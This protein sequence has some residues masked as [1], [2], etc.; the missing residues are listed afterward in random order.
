M[1]LINTRHRF[2][3]ALAPTASLLLGES[4]PDLM[5]D[6]VLPDIFRA[7]LEK[8]PDR[9]VF[10]TPGKRYSYREVDEAANALA[11]GLVQRGIG[12]RDVVGLW[13]PRGVPVLVAQLAISRTG[14]AW[15]P[16][17]ADTPVERIRACLEDASAKA[18]LTDGERGTLL[19]GSGLPVLVDRTVALRGAVPPDPR[20][21]GLLPDHP[22][23][24]IY[25]SGSTGVPKGI[26]IT[27]RNI[28]HF[29]LAAR[30]TYGIA[31]SDVMF[32]GASVAFDLSM[33]E[34]WLPYAVGASL[35]VADPALMADLSALP[36]VLSRHGVTV[37]DTVPTLLSLLPEDVPSLRIIILG[38]EACPP[39]IASRWCRPGRRIFNSYGPTEATVVATAAEIR[40]GEAITIGKPIP[41]YSCYVVDE[42]L[43]LVAEGEEGELLIGGPGVARGYLNRPEL[44]LQKFVPNPFPLSSMDPVLYRTG[45]AVSVDAQGNL[46]FHGRLDDQVKIRG[47]RVELG[48][49]EARLS[50]FPGIRQA[51]VVLRK[52]DGIER[53]VGFLVCDPPHRAD[54]DALRADLARTLPGYMVPARLV[55]LERLPVLIS[56]KADRKALAAQPL[57]ETAAPHAAAHPPQTPTEE[58][59]HAAACALFPG[60]TL[61]MEAD[62][63]TDFGG[64][65]LLAARFLSLVRQ[66]PAHAGLG[67]QDVYRDRT[68]RAM[69]ARLDADAAG[70]AGAADLSFEPPPLLRRF[71]CGLA[72]AAA[73]PLVLGLMSAQFLG[74]FLAY[75]FMASGEMGVL[76]EMAALSAI[77][78]GINLLTAAI[79]IGLKWLVLGRTRPGRYP[80]WGVYYYRWWLAQRLI[81]LIHMKWVQ[82][83]PLMSG[84]LRLLGAR[85]GRD[86]LLYEIEAGAIDLLDIG[87]GVSVGGHC[88]FAN[89]QV[90]GNELVIGTIEIG[91]DAYIGSSCVIGG[92]SRIGRGAELGDLTA[93]GAGSVIGAGE[94]WDGSP[95][96][97]IGTV[98]DASLPAPATAG[99]LRRAANLAVYLIAILSIPAIGLIPLVP[100]FFLINRADA[101]LSGVTAL[102]HHWF[103]PLMALPAALGL[104]AAT[105][106]LIVAIRWLVLPRLQEG[107]Y[108]VHGGTY[109]R[110]WIVSLC[111]EV[112]LETLSSLYATVYM[113]GWYRLMGARI[114]K[115]SEISTSLSGRY[116]L[117][118]IGA[119]CF[120]AD[121]VLLGEED[122][123]RGWMTLKRVR[124]GDQVFVG[125]SAVVPVGT[126]IPDRCL[127][128]IKSKPPAAGAMAAGETWF[129][130][131]AIRLPVRQQ[132]DGGAA[133]TF[134]PSLLRQVG[135]GLFEAL[136][137]LSVPTVS[138]IYFGTLA[139][140]ALGAPLERGA[141]GTALL[142]LPV[143]G[144]AM[145]AAMTLIVVIL[146][147][148]MMG[149][150]R[151]QSNPMWSWFS[152]RTEAIAVMYSGMA[153]RMLLDFL[154]G[155][156]FLPWVLR[157]FGAR[158]GKGVYLD[159]TDITEFD[160]ICVGNFVAVNGFAALQTHL[161]EDR[162]MKIGRVRVEDGV[163]VEAGSTVLY[164]SEVG[165]FARL[166]P[167]TIVM[168][169][170]RI[171]PHTEWHGAP[172]TR[173]PRL[174]GLAL[175]IVTPGRC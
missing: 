137:N 117:V 12:P 66:N 175:Q 16:F 118:E 126:D 92:N 140:E 65:S 21:L 51:A 154:R 149:T 164:D 35:F 125:N 17:D 110:K 144:M 169:G 14:A 18:L 2:A 34:I 77:Y 119:K 60:A 63:F 50:A 101:W 46:R 159:M 44:T 129:G 103:L 133:R 78:L 71:L 36:G 19:A 84:L 40:P 114:G 102:D 68:L 9:T 75:W 64:H 150:Y 121:E 91:D 83:T 143:L 57:P 22:A 113:R 123:R 160:C 104:V 33:E 94:R 70:S 152:L 112:A 47:F 25:T 173:R 55:E 86:T 88:G 24:Y 8:G 52:D 151:P 67:L 73:M 138:M 155:T 38:G 99:R 80:L 15:L 107:V 93:I 62:F 163:T 135:R 141:Y 41:N 139:I 69:A 147:W 96:R 170:E 13:F 43:E 162:V 42:A 145:A 48:E 132:F 3:T 4:R 134:E 157:L 5:A 130:S 54:P 53:L 31:A 59:L 1:N 108:S 171:P 168:K 116:D 109:L 20:R 153:A 81:S 79:A 45:D 136:F 89:A 10:V 156:P 142:L 87:A 61:S 74:V 174:D 131:P 115:G 124:T 72:Q 32:Q 26:E 146:K 148:L 28:C 11:A 23:Y 76:A 97:R 30:E 172:A 105:V 167:L 158:F 127:I 165:A 7:G 98:D 95:A 6:L 56:G 85:I 166:G 27:H 39:A 29:L 161:Y 128:G 122:I 111:S 37:M 120:I 90:I 100:A 106:A 82:G 58:A 49:I